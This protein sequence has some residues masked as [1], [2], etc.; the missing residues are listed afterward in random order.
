M[1]KLPVVGQRY[2]NIQTNEIVHASIVETIVHEMG[3][4]PNI[5]IAGRLGRNFQIQ[6]RPN[7]F[8]RPLAFNRMFEELPD[9]NSQKPEEVQVNKTTN[10]VDLEK[11]EVSEVERAL[12]ELKRVLHDTPY[13]DALHPDDVISSRNHLKKVTENL[14]NALKAEKTEI[15][16]KTQSHI[17]ELD[18]KAKQDMSKPEP[19]IDIKEERVEPVSIWKDVSE[20]PAIHQGNENI[21]IILKSGRGDCNLTVL[22]DKSLYFKNMSKYCTLT[23]F[24]NTFEQMQ[25][26]IAEIKRK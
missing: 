6:E 19:K 26:D 11:K 1:N 17:S 5:I 7:E 23:D 21:E 4:S 8:W 18:L 10:P 14:V 22:G 13:S 9:S 24:I 3:D 16:L 25:K 2:K 12:E 15:R 20:L